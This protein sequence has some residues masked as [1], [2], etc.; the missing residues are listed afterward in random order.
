MNS[1][2]ALR[3]DKKMSDVKVDTPERWQELE[4][5]VMVMVHP[6]SGV[7]EP[8]DFDLE[9]GR[10][11]VMASRHKAGLIVVSRDHVGAT[12]DTHLPVAEQ[13]VGRPDVA[14]RGHEQNGRFWSRLVEQNRIVEK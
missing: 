2:M 6:L 4:R 10:L 5:P 9:T 14:G 12:L 8:S 13:P 11:C 1:A 7:T 3:L